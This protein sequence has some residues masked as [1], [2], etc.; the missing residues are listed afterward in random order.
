M[1]EYF[2]LNFIHSSLHPN[3]N[4]LSS[5]LCTWSNCRFGCKST[6][7][8]LDVWINSFTMWESTTS[9]ISSTPISTDFRLIGCFY[10]FLK[11]NILYYTFN[12]SFYFHSLWTFSGG[13]SLRPTAAHNRRTTS[14]SGCHYCV[15]FFFPPDQDFENSTSSKSCLW[16]TW[17]F[18]LYAQNGFNFLC[19]KHLKKNLLKFL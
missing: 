1:G 6:C 16:E 12:F 5:S 11:S 9:T 10:L 18:I 4:R 17:D 7:L 3:L 15:S 8:W 19:I 2:Y 14:H 13:N